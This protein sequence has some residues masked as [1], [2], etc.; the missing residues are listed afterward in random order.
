VGTSSLEDTTLQTNLEAVNE[1][2]YQLRLRNMGG[3]IIID[4]IDMDREQN[5]D[6]V[7][8]A[9][10]EALR[11]D[12]ARTNVLRIS[13]LGLVEMTRKRVQEGLDRYLTEECPTCGGTG[14]VRSRTT[15]TFDIL[16]EIRREA[17]RNANARAVHVNVA[18]PLADVLYNERFSDLE[19]VEREA[20]KPVVV[21]ALEHYG[22][23]QF[24]VYSR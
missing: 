12:R 1:V 7:F 18:P 5:R 9:L 14:N 13:D 21:R 19:W 4:L 20:G 22:P 10:E 15:L 6:K 16:R 2:V 3:I 8:R 24:E 23:E 11:K 17:S